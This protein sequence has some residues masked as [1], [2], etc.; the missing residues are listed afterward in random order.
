MRR[1]AC[2]LVLAFLLL[3]AAPADATQILARTPEQ[4][5]DDAQLVVRGSVLEVHSFWSPDKTKVLTEVI[6]AVEEDF[7][8]DSPATVRLL[9]LGGVV[10]NVRVT[11]SGALQWRLDEEVLLFLQPYTRDSYQVSGFSQGKFQIHR[12]ART[13]E[14]YVSRAA[15]TG[16]EMLS[17]ISGKAPDTTG[18]MDRQTLRSFLDTALGQR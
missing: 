11:V 12:D 9:Q 2:L 10:D 1:F 6:V 14:I 17:D 15:L 7:K 18:A 8:G 4:L 16:V 3:A 5:G 13:D